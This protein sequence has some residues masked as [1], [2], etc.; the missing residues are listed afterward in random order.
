METKVFVVLPNANE[1][2][3]QL[4]MQSYHCIFILL[5]FV[6]FHASPELV[7]GFVLPSVYFCVLAYLQAEK[8][9]YILK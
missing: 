5:W 2:N 7:S 8:F 4:P 6:V 1:R 3:I 9:R